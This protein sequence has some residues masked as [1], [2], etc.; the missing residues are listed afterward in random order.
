M[1]NMKKVVFSADDFGKCDEMDY[2]I[3]RGFETG[4]L[5]STCIM[6]NGAN[7]EKAMNEILP[8]IKNPD[9]KTDLSQCSLGFHFNIIEGMSQLDKSNGSY[10]CDKDGN[11]N[12]GYIY[13]LLHS[14]FNKKFLNEVEQEFRSQIEKLLVDTKERG[15]KI[16]HVNSHVHV[17]SIPV[18]FD[19]TCALAKEYGIDCVRTTYENLYFAP[20][21]KYR[22]MGAIAVFLNIIKHILLKTLTLINRHA[23]KKYGLK[24]ND[25]FI[26]L[27][28]TGFMDEDTVLKGLD[29]I[30]DDGLVEVVVH[31]YLY[32]DEKNVDKNKQKEFQ[33]V[34][35]VKFRT[36]CEKK[37]C[38]F[39][40]YSRFNQ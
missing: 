11:Y 25:K 3:L 15:F 18:I 30:I 16:D 37:G 28:F 21:K 13:M 7:Y 12:K 8:Q 36:I 39:V 27:L 5:T 24:T 17:H 40:N 19:I 32:K 4:V 22:E 38:K 35:N 29:S 31:P 1:E 6:S 9:F 33:I 14:L 34:N 26:G 23:V 20:L 10:L 2:A